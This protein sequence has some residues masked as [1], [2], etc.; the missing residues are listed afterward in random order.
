MV[1]SETWEQHLECLCL[2]LA[3][4]AQAHLTFSLMKCEFNGVTVTY[5]SKVLWQGQVRPI[6]AKVRV[7]DEYHI[8]AT[9]KELMCFL[10]MIGYYCCA[11]N[12]LW[13]SPC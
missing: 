1:I 11:G 8:P 12:F 2:L 13:L 10:G 3:H 4:L 5:L 6:R 9:K 7:I